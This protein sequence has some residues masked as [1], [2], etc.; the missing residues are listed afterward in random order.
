MDKLIFFHLKIQFKVFKP[1]IY[2][3]LQEKNV[4]FFVGVLL[5]AL[6]SILDEM[7]LTTDDWKVRIAANF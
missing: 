5:W 6:F 1:V 4:Y 2:F 3:L 7:A